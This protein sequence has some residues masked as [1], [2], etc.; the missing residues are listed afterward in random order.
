[1]VQALKIQVWNLNILFNII[2]GRGKFKTRYSPQG[3][4][5]HVSATLQDNQGASNHGIS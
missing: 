2:Q 3:S 4:L 1:M 5:R